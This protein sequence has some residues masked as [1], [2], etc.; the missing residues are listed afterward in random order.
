MALLL[1]T[2]YNSG[3]HQSPDI[4]YL[5]DDVSIRVCQTPALLYELWCGGGGVLLTNTTQPQQQQELAG[6]SVPQ[7]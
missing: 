1:F 2:S 5:K 7:P 3:S 6:L 4:F